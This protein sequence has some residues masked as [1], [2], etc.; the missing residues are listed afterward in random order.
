MGVKI[1]KPPSMATT[2]TTSIQG[3]HLCDKYTLLV[4]R[5]KHVFQSLL[6]F[7]ITSLPPLQTIVNG[8]LTL[9][10][11]ENLFPEW[12]KTVAVHQIISP[13]KE[14]R[15]NLKELMLQP[16]PVCRASISGNNRFIRFD[17][18]PLVH[19]WYT[20]VA[21]N[22]GIILKPGNN[23]S[24]HFDILG[25]CSRNC[26]NSQCWPSLEVSFLNSDSVQ[27]SCQ[28]LDFDSTVITGSI[29][30][31]AATLNIQRYNYT[32]FV[33][34]TG[35]NSAVI[36]LQVSP[37]G[38]NWITEGALQ[39]ISPGEIVPLV[40]NIIAKFARLIFQSADVQQSTSLAIRVRGFSS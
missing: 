3:R 32:Y 4:G 20:G 36:A 13:W 25:F 12:E 8:T 34:N 38:I 17:I 24:C 16:A 27:S 22:L 23:D 11:F 7:D 29:A 6:S 26:C 28:T 5:D 15:V 10:L 14:N 18:T 21:A 31:T 39:T 30:N 35:Q 9:Y 19:N 33:I 40:P 2:A 37:D 1:I